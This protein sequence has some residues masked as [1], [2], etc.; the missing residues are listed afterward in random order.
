MRNC[1]SVRAAAT[2]IEL[3]VVIAIV[4][5]LGGLGLAGVQ[6]IRSAAAQVSCA[7]QLKQIGLALHSFHDARRSFPPGT[8]SE[9]KDRYPYLNWH[10]RILPFLEQDAV[11]R[12]IVEAFRERPNFLYV[13]PHVHR[14]TEMRHFVCPADGRT[15]VFNRPGVTAATTFL[16]SAGTSS[17]R[18]NGILFIDSAVRISEVTDGTTHTLLVGERPPSP[19]GVYGWWYAGWGQGKTG[20]LD[21]VIGAR[22]TNLRER[23]D[24]Q[25]CPIGPYAFRAGSASDHCDTFHFWSRHPGGAHFLFADGTVRF[26]HYGADPILPALATR[27]G[28]ETIRHP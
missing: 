14:M 25:K 24:D 8:G 3:L 10:A 28:G 21:G 4:T 1:G 5:L 22:E 23:E 17:F 11:W 9:A 18:P 19:D 27:S 20:S 12:E 6:K 26:V 15:R 7:N 13:P 2:L 16:G